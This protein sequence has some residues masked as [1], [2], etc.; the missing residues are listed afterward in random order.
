VRWVTLGVTG[1][2]VRF[3]RWQSHHVKFWDQC[4]LNAV[5]ENSWLPLGAEMNCFPFR[6]LLLPYDWRTQVDKLDLS[7]LLELEERAQIVHFVGHRK[8]WSHDYPDMWNRRRY[9]ALRQFVGDVGSGAARYSALPKW[10]NRLITHRT[11]ET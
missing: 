7:Y 6:D 4:A 9:A 3:L 11:G 2:V 5:L 1:E 10:I 8:P